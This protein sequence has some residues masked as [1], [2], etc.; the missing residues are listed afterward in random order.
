[1]AGIVWNINVAYA[2]GLI[3]TDGNLS[4][5]G[6]HLTFVSKDLSLVKLFKECL[7]LT[8]RISCK[9]SGFVKNGKYHFIQ[10]GDVVFYKNLVEIGLG[11]N[12]SKRIGILNIPDEFFPD[13]LRGHLDGDGTIR[14]YNDSKFKNC[15]RLYLSFLSASKRHVIWLQKKIQELYAIK[16]RIRPDVRIWTL[17]YAKHASIT[18]LKVIYYRE[19]LPLLLRK[20]KLINGFLE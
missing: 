1:M 2:I 4:K 12:K 7:G 20:Y 13:F 15:K 10:F 3:T 9:N 16:G 19:N 5:D 17:T 14:T 8:N 11:P 18:L 6:R